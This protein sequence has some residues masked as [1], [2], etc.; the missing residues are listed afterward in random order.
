MCAPT[1]A[2]TTNQAPCWQWRR[3]IRLRVGSD[4]DESGAV[5]AVTP[6]NQ[7]ARLTVTPM[8]KA[9]RWHWQ[10]FPS[11]KNNI[12]YFHDNERSVKSGDSRHLN[13]FLQKSTSVIANWSAQ[14]KLKLKEIIQ[15]NVMQDIC[16]THV[17]LYDWKKY[18]SR[19]VTFNQT[20]NKKF[21]S[22]TRGWHFLYIEKP[23]LDVGMY[24]VRH[25]HERHP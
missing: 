11:S 19:S 13:L 24:V 3:R 4:A 21:L 6:T 17:L 8:N 9:P 18:V 15:F 23:G 20:V 12:R 16:T 25:A 14:L 5:L 22:A 2:P 7:A 1:V 10:S